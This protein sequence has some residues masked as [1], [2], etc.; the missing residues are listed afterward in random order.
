MVSLL[1]SLA[2]SGC[3]RHDSAVRAERQSPNQP[4]EQAS[5]GN[6]HPLLPV[7]NVTIRFLDGFRWGFRLKE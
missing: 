2:R 4:F 6:F 3:G 7:A 5:P 1:P